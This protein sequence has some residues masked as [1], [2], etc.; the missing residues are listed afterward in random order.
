MRYLVVSDLHGSL[1]HYKLIAKLFA[2]ERAEKIVILGDFSYRYGISDDC[3]DALRAL[4]VKPVAIE[5]NCDHGSCDVPEVDYE[6]RFY[7][8]KDFS[9][10]LFFT[11]GDEYNVANVPTMLGEGDVLCY[12]HTHLGALTRNKN[13]VIIANCGSLYLPRHGSPPSYIVID[14]DGICLKSSENKEIL[15][16]IAFSRPI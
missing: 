12:G 13:G 3:K 1:F 2:S 9:R 5:G 11:H 10:R 7:F 16:K 6:G 15:E 4:P 14:E 8:V